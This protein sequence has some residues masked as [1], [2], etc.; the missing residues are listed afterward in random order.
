M[1]TSALLAILPLLATSTLTL[2]RPTY[3]DVPQVRERKTLSFGPVHK[4]HSFKVVDEPIIVSRSSLLSE[5]VDPREVAS[6]FIEDKIG[7]SEGDAFYIRDDSYTDKSTGIT[8]IFAKQVVNGLEVSDGDLNLNIDRDGHIISWGNSFHPGDVPSLH[9]MNE[10][11][12]GETERT[13][14]ILK[15]HYD[16]HKTHLAELQGEEG[17]WGLVKSAAQVILGGNLTPKEIDENAIRKVHKSMR[18]IKHHQKALC[19]QPF[20]VASSGILSPIEGLISLL[21]RIHASNDNFQG[22]SEIDFASTSQHEFKPKS[23][24][25][26]PPTEIISGPGLDKSGVVS[27]IPARLMYTQVTEGSPRLVWNYIVEMK[28]SWYEAYVDVKTG[29]LLR[30]VDWA[31]DLDFE[32]STKSNKN[33]EV[34]KGGGQKPLPTPPKYK[35][36]SYQVF[37]WGVNDPSTGN[38]SVVTNPW[39]N[40]ASPLGW[41]EFPTFA[42]PF[43]TH[44]EGQHVGKNTTTFTTTTGNNVYAHEDWEGRNNFLKNYRPVANDSV[45]V[46]DYGEPDGLKP[47]EYIDMAVTQLFYTSNVYHDLLHRVGFDELSGNFQAY[48]FERGGLGGDPVI[49]NAQDGSGYNNA[50]FMTPPDGQAPRMRM[51][52]WDTATPYR[53]GDL[54]AGIVIHEY[55]HGLSTR[56]TGGPSSSSCL[57]WGEAGGMGEGWGDAVATLIRQIEEHHNYKNGT[58]TYGMGAW[59]ANNGKGIRNFLYSTDKEINPST[60]KFLNK[61]NYWGVHAIGEVWAQTTFIVSQRL[62]E[63]YGFGE[64]LFPPEDISK[65]ND[66]YTKT[67]LESVDSLG[68]PVPLIPKHGNTLLLQLLIDGMKLQPCRPSFFD[69]RDAIIQAD[70]IRTGGANE[71]ILWNAFAESGLGVDASL[72]GNT[73]WGGGR[74]ED[75]FNVPKKCKKSKH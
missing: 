58:D 26:E 41:H 53:D 65:P 57:G 19:Q 50:N 2:A 68:R 13:C 5:S 66:Y 67:S 45:F 12:S 36:Y 61:G 29:E 59:A 38:L 10:G 22:V 28:D 56:L 7:G 34:K 70:K 15:D 73:P 55:S 35:P 69:A 17:A 75:G 9:D 72:I 18:H 31:T 6:K 14:K 49:C 27:D 37:P 43:D 74:R 8:R 32:P 51:Y 25:A 48:N 1:R 64:T 30:I 33:V 63:E 23:A 39:D 71:C 62:V 21:P 3:D 40:V 20:T 46:Y 60:Y 4:H 42:N 47:T 11:S 54:E 24:P 44:I 16:A 52:I